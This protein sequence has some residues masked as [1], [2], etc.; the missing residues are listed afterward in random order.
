MWKRS[1]LT[2]HRDMFVAQ[3]RVVTDFLYKDMCKFFSG[4]AE[5]S[6]SNPNALFDI[7]DSLC[8]SSCFLTYQQ[9][10]IPQTMTGF[11]WV[12]RAV[13][14]HGFAP[15]PIDRFQVVSIP[16]TISTSKPLQYGVPQGVGP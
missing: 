14:S 9:L 4:K 13:P 6:S 8:F 16:G 10:S 7:V 3:R 2:I 11:S 15:T 12:W 1:N 5:K